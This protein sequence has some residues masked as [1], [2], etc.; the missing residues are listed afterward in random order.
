MAA[1]SNHPTIPSD[2]TAPLIRLLDAADAMPG[3]AELRVHS[4]D[5]LGLRPDQ[6]VVD[7]G[8]GSGRAVAELAEHGTRP[9]GIDVSEEM[10]A[11]ARQRWP[12]QEFRLGTADELPLADESVAGYRA[13]KV[14]HELTDPAAAVREARRVLVAG[15]RIVLVG[16]D[17]D[18][19]VIDS[20]DPELTRRIVHA[21]ADTIPSPRAARRYRNLLLDTGFTDVMIEV[22]VAVFTDAQMLPMLTGLADAA[23]VTGLIERDHADAW[24]AEQASRAQDDRLFL[25][26]PLFLAAATHP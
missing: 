1:M 18:A 24:T 7:V 20:D 19:F 9:V 6:A 11:V 4:Y 16:Q 13:D 3:A 21:R 25:A 10:L 5:L 8:C 2:A 22:R 14:F 15:G 23:R 26:M 12:A 17:W